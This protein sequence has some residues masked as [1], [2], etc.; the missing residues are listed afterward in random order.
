MKHALL[1]CAL[2]L[3]V[4]GCVSTPAGKAYEKL[5]DAKVKILED[6]NLAPEDRDARIASIDQQLETVHSQAM[7]ETKLVQEQKKKLFTWGG[8]LVG[9]ALGLAGAAAK[10]FIGVG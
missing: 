9:I 7:E 1:I 10:K 5:I 3:G 8:G 6:P 4:T 2:I